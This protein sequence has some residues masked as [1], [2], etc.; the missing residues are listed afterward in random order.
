M[1]RKPETINLFCSFCNVQVEAQV[2]ARHAV[3]K[4]APRESPIDPVDSLHH[5]SEYTFAACNRCEGP[6]VTQQEFNEIPG[7]FSVPETDPI[8]VYPQKHNIPLDLVPKKASRAYLEALR[9][10]HCQLY[11]PCV[12]M[13]RKCIEAVCVELGESK[14]SL[15]QRLGHLQVKGVID[16]NILQWANGIRIV[17]NDAA[18]DLDMQITKNDAKDTLDFTEAVLLYVFVLQSRYSEFQKRR[19]ETKKTDDDA[20]GEMLADR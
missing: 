14:K 13:C 18:H 17:G 12:I 20:A 6:C 16:R 11:E 15:A 3:A 4:L 7:E 10:Y 1:V 2:L 5:V 19:E 8:Q 9:G